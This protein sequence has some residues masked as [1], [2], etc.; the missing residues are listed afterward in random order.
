MGNT[1]GR[2]RCSLPAGASGQTSLEG[3]RALRGGGGSAWSRVLTPAPP[4]LG[5]P[6]DSSHGGNISKGLGGQRGARQAEGREGGW[7]G[8]RG[9]LPQERPLRAR[10][11]REALELPGGGS[12]LR[13]AGWC[14]LGDRRSRGVWALPP[15]T[16]TPPDRSQLSGSREEGRKLQTGS[17]LLLLEGSARQ[18]CPARVGTRRSARLPAPPPL[19]APLSPAASWAQAPGTRDPGAGI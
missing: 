19:D 1:D 10:R 17:S 11:E 5:S 7:H 15:C 3:R 13:E 12:A 2:G 16:P 14:L 18:A 9:T 8:N 6:Q 4:S